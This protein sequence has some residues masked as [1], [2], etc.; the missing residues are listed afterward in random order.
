MLYIYLK[1][2]LRGRFFLFY[3]LLS[4]PKLVKH[5]LFL[6]LE[7]KIGGKRLVL[8]KKCPFFVLFC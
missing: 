5:L 7:W 8:S 6:P 4:D 2:A 1:P 3:S